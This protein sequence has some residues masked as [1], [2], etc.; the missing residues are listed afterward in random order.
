[1]ATPL[2]FVVTVAEPVNV[3]LSPEVGAAKVT[4][5]PGTGLLLPSLTV[6]CI[7]IAN[8]VPTVALCGVPDV[9][10][11]LAGGGGAL[12]VRL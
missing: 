8:P 1:M 9:A 10:V 7:A 11:M 3:P 6:A 2:E 5:A 12:F 4:L